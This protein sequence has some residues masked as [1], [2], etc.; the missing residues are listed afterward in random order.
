[1]S[2]EVNA[3]DVSAAYTGWPNRISPAGG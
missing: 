3:A 2:A 1:M